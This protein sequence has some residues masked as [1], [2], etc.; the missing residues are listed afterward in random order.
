VVSPQP[1][2]LGLI[3]APFLSPINESNDV[4]LPQGPKLGWRITFRGEEQVHICNQ[5][6]LNYDGFLC[7]SIC[8]YLLFICYY[9]FVIIYLLL[10]ICYYLFVIIYLLLF[11]IIIIIIII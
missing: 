5:N 7:C 2:L 6:L 9:L 4:M 1:S 10:F 8:Y 11:I 3:S